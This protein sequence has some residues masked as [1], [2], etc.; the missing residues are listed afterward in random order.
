MRTESELVA[1]ITRLSAIPHNDREDDVNP[2]NRQYAC[3]RLA[4]ALL[5]RPTYKVLLC[6]DSALP[7]SPWT[8]EFRVE[9][10]DEHRVIRI[11][12]DMT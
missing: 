9:I 8:D 10:D 11:V 1:E 7:P 5:A 3:W 6:A 4:L 12:G 2:S